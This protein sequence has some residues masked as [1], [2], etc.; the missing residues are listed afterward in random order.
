MLIEIAGAVTAIAAGATAFFAWRGLKPWREEMLGRRRA[1]LAERVL[2]LAYEARDAIDAARSP[3][4][5]GS[6][7]QPDDEE[8]PEI[9]KVSDIAPARRLQR[10]SELFAGLR[11]RRY[12]FMAVFGAEAG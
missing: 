2:A 3:L 7:L 8:D 10:E 6:E 11:A 1:E 5:F 9:A 12:E 4:V